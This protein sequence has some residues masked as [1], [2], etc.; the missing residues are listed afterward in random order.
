MKSFNLSTK[1][2]KVIRWLP[3]VVIIA[4]L[5]MNIATAG[6]L[7]ANDNTA[8]IFVAIMEVI[9]KILRI[10]GG[11][12]CVF[13]IVQ[14]VFAFKNEDADS[15]T[16]AATLLAVGVALFLIPNAL[17]AIHFENFF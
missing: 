4:F 3:C 6:V 15:K 9:Y 11:F 13:G 7:C 14:M 2:L 17:E 1:Q 16:R 12:V 8:D 5:G 10:V